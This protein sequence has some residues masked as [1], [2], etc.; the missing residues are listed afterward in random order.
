MP[1]PVTR[2]APIRAAY[3]KGYSA[4]MRGVEETANPYVP[5]D[6]DHSSGEQAHDPKGWLGIYHRTWL[7]GWAD[8]VEARKA[9]NLAQ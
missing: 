4:G 9:K 5:K 2:S 6:H 8:G 7:S 3:R 1:R